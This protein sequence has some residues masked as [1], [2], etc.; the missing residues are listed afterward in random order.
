M[1][2]FGSSGVR[3]VANDELGPAYVLNVARAAGSVFGADRA[4]LARDTRTTGH[5]FADAAASG[6]ASVGAGVDR[7]ATRR[8]H[9]VDERRP[10][11][12]GDGFAVDGNGSR[13]V[14]GGPHVGVVGG[15][16]L[17]LGRDRR[18]RLR[19]GEVGIA[20]IPFE[21]FAEI[22]LKLKNES[23]FPQTF[24]IELANGSYG[25]LPTPLQH[26]LG[27]YETWLGTST[28]EK[29]ASEKIEQT[30]LEMLDRL[31]Q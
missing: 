16:G 30:I 6:L 21:V 4:A 20:A 14:A 23:P 7:N 18:L 26:E 11:R 29:R 10:G 24:T 9:G 12:D 17:E 1:E 19:I 31:A 27:G 3:G 25:Y 28:V 5:L 22:G 15:A 13:C 2:V 8:F